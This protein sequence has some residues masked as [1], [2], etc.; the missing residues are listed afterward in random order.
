MPVVSVEFRGVTLC[1]DGKKKAL[2][3]VSFHLEKG[4]SLGL[5]GE[6]GSG[7][8]SIARLI[9]RF[10]EANQGEVL[11]SGNPVR[12]VPLEELRSRVVFASQEAEIFEASVFENIT[13]FNARVRRERVRA[14]LERV[15]LGEWLEG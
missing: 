14:E 13:L 7:K 11:L 2:D 3:C 8:S 6:T 9:F 12:S 10:Y 5:V 4:K 15:G 1:Y